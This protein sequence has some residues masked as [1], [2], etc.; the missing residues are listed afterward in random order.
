MRILP[1][2]FISS[3]L[4][5]ELSF[6]RDWMVPDL[7]SRLFQSLIHCTVFSEMQIYLIMLFSCLNPSMLSSY[8][9]E[10][11]ESNLN[12]SDYIP[13]PS[14]LFL[15]PSL[16][17]QN[18]ENLCFY[19][20]VSILW[21]FAPVLPFVRSTVTDPFHLDKSCLLCWSTICPRRHH[22]SLQSRPTVRAIAI[23]H[24]FRVRSISPALVFLTL[25]HHFLFVGLECKLYGARDH[26]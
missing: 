9:L 7:P 13:H 16:A 22:S 14:F 10:N 18:F 12:S 8:S 20:S 21:V 15:S 2:F 11:V 19:L 4:L 3:T 17:R 6:S 5:W 1:L 26:V 24:V 23:S 25:Y